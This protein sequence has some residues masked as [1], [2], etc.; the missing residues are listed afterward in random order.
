MRLVLSRAGK[1]LSILV[2]I[3]LGLSLV[4]AVLFVEITLHPRRQPLSSTTTFAQ[5]VTRDY[6]ARLRDALV[7][8]SDGTQLKG[9]Y[10]KPAK[11]NGNA[12]L[13]IHGVGDNR[14]GM[15]GY[16]RLF[17]SS[18]YRVLMPDSRAQGESGGK[19]ATFGL[20]ERNDVHQWVNWLYSQDPPSCVF[21]FGESMGAAIIL[22]S[23]ALEPR[24]C[25]VAVESPFANFD[26][27]AEER[28]NQAVRAGPWFAR[29]LGRPLV[30]LAFLYARVRYKVDLR[31]SSPAKAIA[32]SNTPVLMIHGDSDTNILPENSKRL[33]RMSRDSELWIVPGAGHGGAWATQ[34]TEFEQR[35]PA[36]FESHNH[37]PVSAAR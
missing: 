29:T 21:A 4:G 26:E 17:L 7:T 13:L 5:L 3:Y 16:A 15:S 22:Q 37:H 20:L 24:F 11:D 8:S 32:A 9:W 25:A 27:I 2:L 28:L 1:L 14:T 12:I 30:E 6:Q 33:H 36:W 35:V 18:G 23:L 10:I 31:S 19:F 34:P